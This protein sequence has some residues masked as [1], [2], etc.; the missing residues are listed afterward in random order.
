MSVTVS[1]LD[2]IRKRLRNY[3]ISMPDYEGYTSEY[4]DTLHEA[5]KWFLPSDPPPLDKVRILLA[6]ESGEMSIEEFE[7]CGIRIEGE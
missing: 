3:K 6:L 5:E 2:A 4:V 7:W 1:D